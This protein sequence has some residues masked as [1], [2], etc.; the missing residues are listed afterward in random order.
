M[1]TLPRM[2]VRKVLYETKGSH[3]KLT[4]PTSNKGKVRWQRGE[5]P[6]NTVVIHRQSKGRVSVDRQNRLHIRKVR[7]KDS[8]PYNCWVWQ[9]HIA[10]FKV[11]VFEPMNQNYKDY[12]TY[13]GLALTVVT[14]PLCLCCKCCWGRSKRRRR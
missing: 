2:V 4:C 8:A 10:T 1:P 6:I 13:G 7:M 14:I 3:V 9:S 5:R 12:I 11:V